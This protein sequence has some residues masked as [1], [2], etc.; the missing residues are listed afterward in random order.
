MIESLAIPSF[1]V[2]WTIKKYIPNELDNL[3]GN[4]YRQNVYSVDRECKN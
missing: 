4:V 3:A 1:A 2:M